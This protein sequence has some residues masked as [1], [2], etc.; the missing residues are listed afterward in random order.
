[1]SARKIGVTPVNRNLR[2]T[3]IAGSLVIALAIAFVSVLPEKASA[4]DVKQRLISVTGEAKL[5]VKPDMATLSFGTENTAADAQTAQRE[6]SLKM[7]AVI[8]ALYASG[9]SKDDIQTSN[10]NLSPV[11]EWQGEKTQKQVLVGYRCSNTV[12]VRLKDIGKV[13]LVI[14]SATTDGATNVYG[15]TFGLQ[16]PDAYRPTIL[17]AAVNDAKAKADIMASAAGYKVTGVQTMSDGYTS[18]VPVRES[19]SYMKSIADTSVP[20]EAGSVTITATVRIDYTF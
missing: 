19:A 3:L 6:N 10:F 1:M 9:I 17:A 2:N 16:N 5:E 15:I 8:D 14:D 20:I 12:T 18:V 4:E 7:S 11:Y 13:G